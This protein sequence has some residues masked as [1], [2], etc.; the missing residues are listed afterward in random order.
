MGG[1]PR[2]S[3]LCPS[4]P[5]HRSRFLRSLANPEEALFLAC[6]AA[7][8]SSLKPTVVIPQKTDAEDLALFRLI[9]E[10]VES[11][12]EGNF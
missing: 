11:S 6:V 7:D 12:S 5:C 4:F 2:E 9:S 10:K 1:C 3:L 8:G